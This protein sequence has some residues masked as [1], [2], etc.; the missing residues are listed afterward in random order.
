MNCPNCGTENEKDAAFCAECG[1]KMVVE[2]VKN[3]EPV[4]PASQSVQVEV[5]QKPAAQEIPGE[6]KPLSPWAY[7]GWQLLF[8]I[9]VVGF[10]LLIVMSFAPKNKNLK[11][12]ARSYWCALLIVVALIVTIVVLTLALGGSLSAL[13]QYIS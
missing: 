11:N 2:T 4:P 1:T 9:P 13:T 10:V 5:T 12:L 7:F 6:Y 8:A 3:E